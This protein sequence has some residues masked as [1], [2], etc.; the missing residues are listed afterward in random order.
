MTP[1]QIAESTQ[2]A[3]SFDRYGESAWLAC[4]KMLSQRGYTDKQIEAI[5]RSKWMRW[6]GDM[7]GKAYG[8]VTSKD[9]AYWLDS[10]GDKNRPVT[11]N[12]VE[13]ITLETFGV[14]A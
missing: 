10:C 6:C 11:L 1:E 3:Y 7:S 4:C 5:M 8:K 13:Q 2:D 12:D 9:L 14:K